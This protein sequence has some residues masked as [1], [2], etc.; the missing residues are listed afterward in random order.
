[1]AG[2]GGGGQAPKASS[3]GG[4]NSMDDLPKNIV[5]GGILAGIMG[6]VGATVT[7]LMSHH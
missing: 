1:M 4:G 7:A 3:G 2:H 6:V 5:G